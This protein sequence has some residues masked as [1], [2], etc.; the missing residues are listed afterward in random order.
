MEPLS[1][2]RLTELQ[3]LEKRVSVP[4]INQNLLNQAMTHSSYAHEKNLKDNERLEFLGDAVLKLVVTEYIYNK[5][6][7]HDEGDLTKIR[8]AVISDETLAKIGQ[9]LELGEALLLSLNEKK[10]GGSNRKSNL[11]NAFEALIGAVY[12]D[13][14]LGRARDLILENLRGEIEIVSK[15][16]YIRDYKS[17]LQEFVQKNKWTLPQYRVIKENGP[18]HRRIFFVEVKVNGKSLGIGRGNNKKEAEQRAATVALKALK[19]DDKKPGILSRI[20]KRLKIDDK[21]VD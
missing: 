12:L 20:K 6:P 9:Q 2:V 15:V 19:G 21:A 13:A 16:G 17:T 1:P 4:F 10:G 14:G 7:T 8:A 5:F 18:E 11:A 3:D